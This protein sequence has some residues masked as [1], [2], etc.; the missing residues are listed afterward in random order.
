MQTG[1]Q[2]FTHDERLARA[3]AIAAQ[4]RAKF[5]KKIRAIGLYGSLARGTDGP[6]SDIE[7]FCIV[8]GKDFEQNYEWCQG[9]WKAEVNVLSLDALQANAVELD[10]SWPLTHSAYVHILP[11]RDPENLFPGLREL[12]FGHSS[13]DFSQLMADTIV[14]ECFELMGK[15]R[16]AQH[17]GQ[18][19]ALST[20]VIALAR[21]GAYL[22]GLD[23]RHLYSTFGRMFS[24]S[25]FLPNRP[26]AYDELCRVAM[27]GE[28]SEPVKLFKLAEDFW[29]GIET[30]AQERKLP[31]YRSLDDIF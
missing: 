21:T 15:I 16:N 5:G 20:E 27:R 8:K 4:F 11:L 28:L 12:V 1:P 29:Q 6:Y 9:G 18:T 17:S 3:E 2:P 31:V 30:W 7:M 26:N 25:L 10:E 14:W 13:E 22:V 24:E 23:N 19:E